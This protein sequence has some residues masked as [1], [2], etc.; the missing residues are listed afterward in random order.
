MN[1]SKPLGYEAHI[2][3]DRSMINSDAVV[4]I[5]DKYDWKRSA[6]DA[7]PIMGDKP[8]GYLTKYET[9]S[10]KL[11]DEVQ[12]VSFLLESEAIP[13][14]RRKIESILYDT[15]TGVNFLEV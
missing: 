3:F 2:T 14:L 13:V 4:F 7:D 10:R 8:Y 12:Y 11:L 1:T 9:D 6:F 15:K 5:A